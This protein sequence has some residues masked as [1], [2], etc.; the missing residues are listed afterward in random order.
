MLATQSTYIHVHG[1]RAPHRVHSFDMWITCS[2]CPAAQPHT[3][4]QGAQGLPG[5]RTVHTARGT[6]R[7]AQAKNTLPHSDS[8]VACHGDPTVPR[9]P[10][11]ATATPP[12]RDAPRRSTLFTMAGIPRH[13]DAWLRPP[14][15]LLGPAGSCLSSVWSMSCPCTKCGSHI[16]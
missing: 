14:H 5:A 2:S 1:T 13:E 3:P 12:C 9:R 11:R 6:N 16:G 7:T 10:H 8:R 4:G 15:L